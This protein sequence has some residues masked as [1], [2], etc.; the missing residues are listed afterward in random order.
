MIWGTGRPRREFL[1]VD[2][3]ADA[4]L[5]LMQNYDDGEIINVGT[6]EDVTIAELAGMVAEVVGYDGALQ[7]D[8]SKPDGTP[9]KLLENR[10]SEGT[11]VDT[12][13]SAARR[14]GIDSTSGTRASRARKAHSG[15]RAPGSRQFVIAC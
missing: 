7:F 11:R 13:D 14:P 12:A 15:R 6:G 4:A 10:P 2:D 9:R 3:M 5:F 8:A 1:H